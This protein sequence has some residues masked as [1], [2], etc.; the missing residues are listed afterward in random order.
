MA[1]G[2]K[3]NGSPATSLIIAEA[4]IPHNLILDLGE[5]QGDS[6]IN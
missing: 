1:R 6:I 4:G 3:H 5:E 2:R